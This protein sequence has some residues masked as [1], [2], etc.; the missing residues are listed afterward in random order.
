[1]KLRN[2]KTGE[3]KEI[4]VM[5]VEGGYPDEFQIL[6]GET[7]L[8]DFNEFWEDS[9]DTNVTNILPIESE[10]IREII[11]AWAKINGI[12]ELMYDYDENS[13]EDIFRNTITFNPR[14]SLKDGQTYT[15]V[16]LCGEEEE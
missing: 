5:P 6:D 4:V 16:E 12:T 8:K 1:M 3:I 10:E 13:L 11:R 15:I 14:L 2:K 9:A 7:S